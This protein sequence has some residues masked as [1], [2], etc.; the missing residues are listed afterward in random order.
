MAACF[1]GLLSALAGCSCI[2]SARAWGLAKVLERAD[3]HDDDDEAALLSRAR[4]FSQSKHL[5]S[6]PFRK[7]DENSGQQNCS[8]PLFAGA[9]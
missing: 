4:T 5:L 2:V 9:P 7:G 8:L 6:R 1:R 3:E